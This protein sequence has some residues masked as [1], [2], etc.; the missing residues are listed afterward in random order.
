MFDAKG[1][2]IMEDYDAKSTFAS[3]LP[4]ISGRMGIPIW[5][6]YVNRGQ[7]VCSFGSED[8]EH[9]IMEF[10]PAHQSYQLTQ[11]HGFRTF[12][13]SNGKY[14]EPFSDIENKKTMYIG[15]NEL[16]I[17]EVNK[18]SGIKTE[19]LYYTL[20]TEDVG[21]MVRTVKFTNI[22]DKDIELELLDGMPAIITYGTT[23]SS[24]KEMGQT[25]KAWMQVEDVEKAMPYYRVRVSTADSA[26]VTQVLGGNFYMTM[27][28]DGN[29]LPVIVDPDVIF[30]Q[31][32]SMHKAYGFN[33]KGIDELFALKQVKQN[34]LPCAFFGKK[35]TLKAG[36]SYTVYGVIGQV[37][38]KELLESFAE[39]CSVPGYFEK[40]YEEAV[41]LTKDL[42][43]V[44]R[45][46]SADPVFDAYC[47]QTYLDNLLRGGFP[48]ELGGKI[49]YLYSRKH[50]DIER[51]YNFFRMLP[52]FY[53]QGNANFR[54]VNQNRRCDI[55]FT[56]YVKDVNIKTFY[57]LIQL[58]GCNPLSVQMTSYYIT[59]DKTD[60]LKKYVPEENWESLKQVILNPFTPGQLLGYIHNN[61]IELAIGLE[62]FL[63]KAVS[64]AESS[65]NAEFGEGYWSDHWTYNLDLVETYLAIYPDEEERLIYDDRTYTYFES[66]AA[67]LPRSE[68]YVNTPNGV[69][70]Y[71][72]VDETPKKN[73]EFKIA[74]TGYG[75]GE[76][77]KSTL[78]EKLVSLTINKFA[79][80]DS[81][82]MGIEMEGGKPGW[83]D[84]L[85]GLPGIFGSSMCETFELCRMMEFIDGV[86][87]KYGRSIALPFEMCDYMFRVN[88]ALE[89]YNAGEISQFE[90]WN[91]ANNVKENY[92]Q[93]TMYGVNGRETE[94]TSEELAGIIKDWIVYIKAGIDK[95]VEYGGGICPA[96]FSYRLTDFDMDGETVIPKKFEA[97]MMP[98]FLEG[99]VRYLKLGVPMR[100]KALMYDKIKNSSLYDNKLSMYKV[101][102]SLSKA[103]FEVGRAKAFTPGWLEN[104]SI[105]L[106]MEYKYLLEVL[107]SGLYE[108]YFDDFRKDC[109]AF[110]DP[111]VYGRSP[112]ENSSFIAS[113]A[114]PDESIHGK[115]FVARLSGST[116][117]FI[118]MWYIM[119]FGIRPFVMEDGK[120][121]LELSPAIP[122][123]LLDENDSISATFLGSTEVV[124]KSVERKNIIPGSSVIASLKVEFN[125]GRRLDADTGKL[126]GEDAKA[127]RAGKARRIEAVIK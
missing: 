98:L 29:K 76:D 24:I 87:D 11:T 42:C 75:K 50:G 102:E 26:V 46:R 44:I 92:R 114:N 72:S 69:R 21:A 38:K 66:K 25:S 57:N 7:A 120:L 14:F 15:M 4:G 37:A 112:L 78:M 110:L 81:Y 121:V 6:V 116:A 67:V 58:D 83:Y 54:D 39:R 127:V 90:Y 1:R 65:V 16:A 111:E 100:E 48:I 45:T 104:E 122:E 79:A 117:E 119:M 35:L 88:K 118:Q 84:A 61:G 56:P 124:Y 94:I 43:K 5:S 34:K 95:A 71:R 96:Y 17:D 53:S 2:F 93:V 60:V 106:H 99:P 63:D 77:V 8:K 107:K 91:Q 55:L 41:E 125:D 86:N 30:E 9:S 59:E 10:Y 85:N 109:V 103:S 36:E 62:E 70:Q 115:G 22:T 12:I 89:K 23:M 19:V 32:T 27:D 64:I 73:V 97:D 51:D 31:D 3:F 18:E 49:F 80:L 20:P 52:E 113:S 47:E 126:Y 101:D 33:R 108:E 105:W 28:S 123:Y 74:R 82:G 68:R 40:K 13:K